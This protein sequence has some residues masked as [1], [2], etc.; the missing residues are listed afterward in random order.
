MRRLYLLRARERVVYVGNDLNDIG[1]LRLAGCGLA[2]ADA[3]PLARKAARGLLSRP[4]GRGAVREA[5]ELILVRLGVD[6]IYN[7]SDKGK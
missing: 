3:H 7:D 5:A 1:C 6:L 2:V 4:G